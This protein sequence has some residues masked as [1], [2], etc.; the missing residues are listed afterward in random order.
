MLLAR[1]QGSGYAKPVVG[2]FYLS[3]IHGK[4]SIVLF[5]YT[6]IDSGMC[7]DSGRRAVDKIGVEAGQNDLACFCSALAEQLWNQAAELYKP[8]NGLQCSNQLFI[9]KSL[10]QAISV[11]GLE[12]PICSQI[13]ALQ[14]KA[15]N[16]MESS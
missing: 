13:G 11:E 5:L 1:L 3:V 14:R 12:K 6:V 7:R 9:K 16:L 15:W 10:H 2:V 4:A 8:V